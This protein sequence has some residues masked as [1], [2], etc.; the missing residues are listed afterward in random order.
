MVIIYLFTDVP[1]CCPCYGAPAD[2]N[3]K[4]AEALQHGLVSGT[5]VQKVR[6]YRAP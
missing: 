4:Q 5:I 1:F 3:I 2:V 6:P